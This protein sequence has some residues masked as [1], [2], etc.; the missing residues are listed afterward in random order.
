[1]A[2]EWI[3]S[4][5]VT[6]VFMESTGQY[7]IPIFNIF[8]EGTFNQILANPQRIK[9]ILNRKADIKDAEWIAQLGRSGLIPNLYIP[10]EEV[11]QLRYLTRR[12]LAYSQK[13]T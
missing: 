2:L 7:W 9:G 4:Y 13:R 11:L 8:V 5:R 6:D 10:S 12:K 3:E 1:M